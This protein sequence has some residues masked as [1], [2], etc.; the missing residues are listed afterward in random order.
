MAG[1]FQHYNVI[2]VENRDYIKSRDKVAN[3]GKNVNG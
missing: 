1:F 2:P 3:I